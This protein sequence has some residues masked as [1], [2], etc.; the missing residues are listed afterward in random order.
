MHRQILTAWL[1][2]EAG[3]FAGAKTYCEEVLAESDRDWAAFIEA[4]CSAIRG[5]A[6]LGLG[7]HEG[8]LRCF[9][10]FFRAEKNESQPL[11]FNYFFPV[12]QGAAETCLA[13][14]DFK[15]ARYY[16]QRLHDLAVLAPERTYLAISHGLLAEI[17]AIENLMDEADHPLREALKIVENAQTPLAAWRTYHVAEKLCHLW[18]NETSVKEYRVKKTDAIKQLFDSLAVADPLRPFQESG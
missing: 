10:F 18:N 7:D 2:T 4:H 1:H 16:A 15:K 3:D 6:L 5:R 17:S 14:G 8:A 11:F 13:M 9:D 12:C